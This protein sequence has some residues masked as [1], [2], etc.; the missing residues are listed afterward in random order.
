MRINV[1]CGV[2][3]RVCVCLHLYTFLM[4]PFFWHPEQVLTHPRIRAQSFEGCVT[5]QNV[6][7]CDRQDWFYRTGRKDYSLSHLKTHRHTQ[8]C[9]HCRSTHTKATIV[10][11]LMRAHFQQQLQSNPDTLLTNACRLVCMSL[12]LCICQS[13]I[14]TGRY[15]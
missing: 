5:S 14:H 2:C 7:E 10:H 6:S 1:Q 8:A 11:L 4:L 13:V 12:S 9:E 3:A 15:Q